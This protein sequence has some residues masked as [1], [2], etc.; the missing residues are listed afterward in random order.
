VRRLLD[1]LG[2]ELDPV[3]DA[4]TGELRVRLSQPIK[5]SGAPAS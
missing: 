5:G 3:Y 2:G 4:K 1:T